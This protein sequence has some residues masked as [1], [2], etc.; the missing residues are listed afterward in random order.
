MQIENDNRIMRLPTSFQGSIPIEM[1]KSNGEK[2][3]QEIVID[4][5]KCDFSQTQTK[6]PFQ[7]EIINAI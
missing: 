6:L 4:N 3:T 5:S 1:T 2:Y 7:Q